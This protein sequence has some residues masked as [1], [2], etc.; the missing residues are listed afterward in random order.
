MPNPEASNIDQEMI[1][2]PREIVVNK[3]TQIN[4]ERAITWVFDLGTGGRVML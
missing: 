2:Q 1:L 4:E 3:D